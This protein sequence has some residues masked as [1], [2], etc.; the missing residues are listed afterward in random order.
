MS[1]FLSLYVPNT[2]SLK[3]IVADCPLSTAVFDVVWLRKRI[4]MSEK[5]VA[6][7]ALGISNDGIELLFLQQSL[8][9]LSRTHK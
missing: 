1:D 9:W 4:F 8:D 7:C 2:K 5:G 6:N 3:F